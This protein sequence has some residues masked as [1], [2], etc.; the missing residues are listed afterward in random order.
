MNKKFITLA[1]AAMFSLAAV[2]GAPSFPGGDEAMQEFIAA[3]LRY[4]DAARRNGIEGV[5]AVTFI[6]KTDGSIGTIKIDRLVDPDLEQE[7][8]RI[9]KIMPAWTPAE[10]NGAPADAPAHVAITFELPDE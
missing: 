8:V 6:V 7:A 10:V 3:N 9:V 4:P 2:A 1:S 5:V